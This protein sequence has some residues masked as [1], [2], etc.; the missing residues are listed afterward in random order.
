MFV[1]LSDGRRDDELM[2][3][4]ET[5]RVRFCYI[6]NHVSVVP[7][8]FTLGNYA[9]A[10]SYLKGERRILHQLSSSCIRISMILSSALLYTNL[11]KPSVPIGSSAHHSLFPI[12]LLIHFLIFSAG[13][14]YGVH[15]HIAVWEVQIGAVRR[16][17]SSTCSHRQKSRPVRGHARS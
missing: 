16:S 8:N 14:E 13:A 17:T 5:D 15:T 12:Y 4:G 3:I 6:I 1:R 10:Y 11:E 9:H 2:P 7:L